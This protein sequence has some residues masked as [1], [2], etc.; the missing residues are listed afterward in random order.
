MFNVIEGM[1]QNFIN[2]IF[3]GDGNLIMKVK[4][5]YRRLLI[6]YPVIEIKLNIGNRLVLLLLHFRK[7]RDHD[8][9]TW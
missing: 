3:K 9:L 1:K 6:D 5:H 2:S 4:K 7:L 8:F